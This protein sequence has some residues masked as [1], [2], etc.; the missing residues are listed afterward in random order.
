VTLSGPDILSLEAVS[1]RAW[2]AA[3]Q[4]TLGGWRLHASSGFSGRINACW[5]LG[6]PGQELDDAI[7]GTEAW[8]A[9]HNLPSRFKIVDDAANAP[10]T[11]TARL[12]ELG[13]RTHTETV[14]MVGPAAGAPD[15]AVVLEEALDRRFAAVFAATADGPGDAQERLETLAR[16]PTPRAFA[17]LDA[18]ASPAAIGACAAD[19]DWAGVFAMRTDA[20]FRRQ[21]LASRILSS[22]MAFAAGAGATRAWLQVEA[23]NAGAIALYRGAGFAEAYRYRYWQR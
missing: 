22:L 1:A 5:P 17:R 10:A 12:A 9:G 2:P 11:L 20:R 3:R 7:A 16:V 21:G 13:Y 4:T 23:D 14:M 18:A 8:Y 6:D 15:S 19:G